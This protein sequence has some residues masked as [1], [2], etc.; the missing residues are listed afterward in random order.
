[1]IYAILA[2]VLL[3][4]LWCA[5]KALLDVTMK[6]LGP[7][8]VAQDFRKWCRD[9]VGEDPGPLSGD[10]LNHLMEAAQMGS[11]SMC[12]AFQELRTRLGLHYPEDR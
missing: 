2:V 7:G 8:E 10:D 1:M 11:D 3:W 5:W 4:A 9:T 6:T 12:L